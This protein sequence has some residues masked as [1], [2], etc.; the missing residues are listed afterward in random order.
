MDFRVIFA[1]H[2]N[3]GAPEMQA[4]G[5]TALYQQAIET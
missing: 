3:P 2:P 1:Y 4:W 5:Y